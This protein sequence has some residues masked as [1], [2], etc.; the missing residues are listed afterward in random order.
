MLYT[1]STLV[2]NASQKNKFSYFSTKTYVVGTRKNRLN[3]TVS[4]ENPKHV[5]KIRGKKIF[6]ILCWN[7]LFI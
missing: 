3:E 1:S 7:F 4:F 5:L 2:K 6:T